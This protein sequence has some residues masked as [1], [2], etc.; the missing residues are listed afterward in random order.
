[1]TNFARF[2][3]TLLLLV[4]AGA[5]LGF[6]L[7]RNPESLALPLENISG[8]IAGWRQTD[9]QPL[10]PSALKRLLPTDFIAR[11]YQKDNRS[12]G[13][14]VAYYAQQRAGESMHS[15]K[16]CLPG[17]GW[18]IWKYDSAMIPDP[19]GGALVEI[20]KYSVQNA[21]KRALVYYWY[22]SQ[23]RILASEYIGKFMLIRDALLDGRTA[24]SIVRIVVDD[25]PDAHQ[26]AVEF[27]SA[28]VPQVDRCFR[29]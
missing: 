28:V 22:Q 19:R 14:F 20:N 7:R 3:I 26:D 21:G 4:G 11:T 10:G 9:A 25:L 12:L 17:S 5:G 2:L 18:E 27:A 13:L 23:R 1:M 24:G 29:R 16:N 8:E 6:S 15:P